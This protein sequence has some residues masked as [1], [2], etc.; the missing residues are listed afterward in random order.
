MPNFYMI[1]HWNIKNRWE[2]CENLFYGE[3]HSFIE[4]TN[5][6]GAHLYDSYISQFEFM[7]Y[8]FAKL[9]LAWL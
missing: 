9:V 3:K 4:W 7:N 2:V 5:V 8:A 6:V 1:I